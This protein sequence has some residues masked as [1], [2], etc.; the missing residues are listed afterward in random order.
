MNIKYFYD[1]DTVDDKTEKTMT[2]TDL[3][4]R[5][6]RLSGDIPF[7]YMSAWEKYLI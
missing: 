3:L 7:L 2:V 4:A 6:E 1:C 5:R